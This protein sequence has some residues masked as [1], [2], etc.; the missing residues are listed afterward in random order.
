M[1]VKD[2]HREILTRMGYEWLN[3]ATYIVPWSKVA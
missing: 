2:A 1:E 3:H